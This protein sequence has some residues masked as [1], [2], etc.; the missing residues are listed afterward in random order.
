ML[1]PRPETEIL[2]DKVVEI[3]KDMDSIRIAEIGTGSGIISIMLAK[4]LK[5]S[6]IIATH[7]ISHKALEVAQISQKC[8]K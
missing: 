2:I 4:L 7:T 6:K 5:N 1:I 3:T 8:T